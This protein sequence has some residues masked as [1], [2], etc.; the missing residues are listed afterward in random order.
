MVPA[1]ILRT[2]D[3]VKRIRVQ[4]AEQE[5]ALRESQ[6]QL[7]AAQAGGQI[8]PLVKEANARRPG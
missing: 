6:Q 3:A 8:A 4:R 2:R 7:D 1:T 5:Q